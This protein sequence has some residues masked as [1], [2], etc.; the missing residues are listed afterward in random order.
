MA[1]E[2]LQF[3]IVEVLQKSVQS[4]FHLKPIIQKGW[5]YIKDSGDFINKTKNLDAILVTADVVGFYPSIP[6]EACLRALREVLDKQ[7][8]KCIPTEDLVKM[9]EFA[10]KTNYSLSLTV[11]LN[12]KFQAQRSVLNLHH[13]MRVF[14]WTSL[15]E[16][17]L[18]RNNC[19]P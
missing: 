18:K 1:L 19:S 2:D 12:N 11:K 10:L 9:A 14:S 5:S 6:H 8:N 13:H 3:L 7:G 15:R 4:F 17:F 16:V